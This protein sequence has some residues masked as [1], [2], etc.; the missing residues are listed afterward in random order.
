MIASAAAR[1]PDKRIELWFQDEARVGQKGRTT[2]VWYERGLRPRK[3]RDVGFASAWLFGAV[4]PERDTGCALL[5]PVATTAAM[6]L[7]MAELSASVPSDAHAVVVLDGAGWHVARGLAVPGNITLLPLPPYSPELNPV[8]KV[9]QYLRDRYLSHRV[10]PDLGAVIDTACDAWNRLMAEPGRVASLTRVPWLPGTA[11][12]H[13]QGA[14][15]AAGPS[16]NRRPGSSYPRS[17]RPVSSPVGS[18]GRPALRS[19]S[20]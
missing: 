9:W 3:P 7:F 12:G 5:L 15:Q 4:C 14:A 1:H 18:S 2:R 17:G 11:E 6:A 19:A 16:P 8:E 20:T 13:H 10:L